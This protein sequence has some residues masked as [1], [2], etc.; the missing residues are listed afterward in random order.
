M[1]SYIVIVWEIERRLHICNW[2]VLRG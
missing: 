1:V 2:S